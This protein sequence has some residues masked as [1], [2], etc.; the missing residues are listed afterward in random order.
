MVQPI[1]RDDRLRSA[2]RLPEQAHE[3]IVRHLAV[4]EDDVV[5]LPGDQR[6]SA[7]DLWVDGSMDRWIDEWMNGLIDE[8]NYGLNYGSIKESRSEGVAIDRSIEIRTEI[9]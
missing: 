4:L 6:R 7:G 8:W 2:C 5:Q 3:G 9:D 1:L